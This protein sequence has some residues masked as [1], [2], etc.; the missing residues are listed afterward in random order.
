M[1]QR[2][3]YRNSYITICILVILFVVFLIETFIGGSQNTYV[4]IKMGAM[5]NYA[6]VAGNQW[7]RLFTAQFLHIGIMHLISNAVMIYY[8]GIY[9]EP[10]LGHWRFLVV[11]LLSGVG[12]NLLSLAWGSD[13]AISA[14]ASTALFGLFG[15]M[16]ATA[17]QNRNNP[18]L[19]YLGKQSFWLALINIALDLFAPNIDIQ[20]HIG[21]L[22]TGFLI[23]VIIGDRTY[24]KYSFKKRVV[25]TCILIIYCVATVRMGMVI[26]L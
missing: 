14:G 17:L 19:V 5:N 9:M 16:T 4:L 1:D 10:I 21:G 6:I 22:V 26:K 11:Y 8:L 18:V 3:R 23:A 13:S 25:A 7:W 2:Q 12:G 24:R 20:G 15:A